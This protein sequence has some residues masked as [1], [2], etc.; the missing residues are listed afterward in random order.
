MQGEFWQVEQFDHLVRSPEQFEHYR[1]RPRGRVSPRLEVAFRRNASSLASRQ[2]NSTG[3]SL[4]RG[5]LAL[6]GIN[7]R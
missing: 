4:R 6:V 3:V 5:I 7:I 1:R 2:R